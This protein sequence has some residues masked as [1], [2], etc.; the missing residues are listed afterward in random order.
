MTRCRDVQRLVT[1]FVDGELEPGQASALRGHSRACSSCSALIEAEAAVRRAAQELEAGLD[2]P[3]SLWAGIEAQLAAAER[4]DASRSWLWMWWQAARGQVFVG[5][6][7]AGAVALAVVWVVA[8]GV[9]RGGTGE[10]RSQSS[11]SAPGQKRFVNQGR[12]GGSNAA[13]APDPRDGGDEPEL[14][15]AEAFA[16]DIIE[17]DRRYR[18]AVAEL[19]QLVAEEREHWSPTAAR[20][21]DA[22][23]AKLDAQLARH[24]VGAAGDDQP[25]SRDALFAVYRSEIALLQDAVLNGGLPE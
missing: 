11:L 5:A 6:A 17:A 19:R 21:L 3:P 23:L 2:P 20:K 16:R 13:P 25:R 22:R 15:I 4:A 18:E 9:G 10:P 8:H 24:R 1:A 12:P 14:E 7:V